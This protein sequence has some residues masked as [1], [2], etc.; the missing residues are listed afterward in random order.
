MTNSL[1]FLNGKIHYT[2]IN[3][4]WWF[5]VDDLCAALKIDAGAQKKR[6]RRSQIL[7][8]GGSKQT[9]QVG[10]KQS[11]NVYC[12]NEKR[13]Y[14]WL[15]GVQSKQPD[16]VKWQIELA[17]MLY[18]NLKGQLAPISAAAIAR[19]QEQERIAKLEDELSKD[20]RYVELVASKQRMKGY[21]RRI[22]TLAN[23]QA[24][25]FNSPS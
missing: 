2:L 25:L 20:P 4:D 13:V 9:L 19:K 14:M 18:E 3:G 7:S 11:R 1:D 17:D 24:T 10:E 15:A 6:I 21:G 8:P 23:K 16:F 22:S 5:R 12:I